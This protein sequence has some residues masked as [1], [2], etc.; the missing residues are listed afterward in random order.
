MRCEITNNDLK[1]YQDLWALIKKDLR[2]HYGEEAFNNWFNKIQF[3]DYINARITLVVPTV[4]IK[5]WVTSNYLKIIH[6][7]RLQISIQILKRIHI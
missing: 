1:Y 3:S 4:F 2:Q 6:Q 7:M 5:D